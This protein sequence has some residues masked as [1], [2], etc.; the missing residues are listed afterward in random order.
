[1]TLFFDYSGIIRWAGHA[2]GIPRTEMCVLDEIR[3]IHPDVQLIVTNDTLGRFHHLGDAIPPQAID[4]C[5]Q[6]FGAPVE[7]SS[8]DTIL[9]TGATWA[10]GSYYSQI[11]TL[12]K[13]GVSFYQ[14]FYDM[15][16]AKYPY[17]YEPGL[18]FGD[19]YGS[20]M[21]KGA[22]LIDG[23]FAISECSKRDVVNW[24]PD[25]PDLEDRIDVIRLGED[26]TSQPDANATSLR[27]TD[28]ENYLLCVG[29]LELRKNQVLLLNSYRILLER[30]SGPL[31][32][33]VMC[34]RDGYANSNIKAQIENDRELR[35]L[36]IIIED[37][38]DAEIEVLFRRCQFSLFP[39]VYE[40]W[41]LPVAESL[42]LGR[43]CICSN[44]SS[45]LEIAPHLTI[46]ASP[47]SALDW[48][49]QI[50]VLLSNDEKL[51]RLSTR[52]ARE[53]IPTNWSETAEMILQSIKHRSSIT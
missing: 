28:I 31:P 46:F 17:L 34:G 24:C 23:G 14:I 30:G 51:H 2:T 12:K 3:K 47:H 20:M 25:I 44:T 15:I 40:G 19:Y 22:A 1:M 10:F 41:G 33:L 9:C 5:A 4:A 36:V 52:V 21:S 11:E 38:S 50:S 42:R 13:N 48:A 49:D 35:D 18:G 37:A 39:A 53:Y 7:F 16:P 43:P 45:M 8:R 32:K 26:F 27:F 29:T 6:Q